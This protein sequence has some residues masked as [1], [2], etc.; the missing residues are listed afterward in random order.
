MN[1]FTLYDLS[2]LAN[3]VEQQRNKV[4]Q[5]YE[6]KMKGLDRISDKI[7]NQIDALNDKKRAELS[8]RDF[9]NEM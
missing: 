2:V 9:F 7:R 1:S 4:T 3:A 6:D 8:E 5:E